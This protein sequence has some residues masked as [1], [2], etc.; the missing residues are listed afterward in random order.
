[1][2]KKGYIK[3]IEAMIAVV[4]TF[5]VMTYILPSNENSQSIDAKKILITLSEKDDFRELAIN[6]TSCVNN[7]ANTT[8]NNLINNELSGYSYTLCPS[9]IKP[10]LPRKNVN[11]ESYYLM[12]KYS[13]QEPKLIRFYYW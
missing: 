3:T 7:E 12:P 10:T 4:M 13:N 1:M 9:E 6:L 8:L 2:N 11:A 5:A